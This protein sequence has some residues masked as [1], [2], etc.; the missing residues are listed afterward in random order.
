ME[1]F[2]NRLTE[3]NSLVNYYVS[4]KIGIVL[5]ISTGVLLTIITGFFQVTRFKL[6]WSKTC[7]SIR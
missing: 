5:L 3:I 1:E 2:V 4:E 7:G 6:W